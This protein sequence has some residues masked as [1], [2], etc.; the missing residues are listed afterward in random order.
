M[1]RDLEE[2]IASQFVDCDEDLDLLLASLTATHPDMYAHAC[3]VA[4]LAGKVARALGI[5]G[6][7]LLAV[8]RGA[9]LHDVGKLAMPEAVLRK[10]APLTAEETRLMRHYPAIGYEV[11]SPVAFL[12]EAVDVVR[13]VQ[14]RVDGHGYPSGRRGEDV[15]LGARVV[16]V[17]DAYDT[18]THPRVF[19]DAM[20]PAQAMAEITKG[21]GRQFDARMVDALRGIVSSA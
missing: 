1:Q 7:D 14:E 21:R 13:D 16:A 11:M 10:P 19:R 9:L 3:R 20:S 6:P 8:E 4:S 17:A 2:V 18:M 12:A 15:C 5:S